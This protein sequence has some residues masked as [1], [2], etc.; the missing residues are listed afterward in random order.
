M[1]QVKPR[2]IM[3]DFPLAQYSERGRPALGTLAGNCSDLS[4]AES[5]RLILLL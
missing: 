3:F 1:S 2:L 5:A 4:R